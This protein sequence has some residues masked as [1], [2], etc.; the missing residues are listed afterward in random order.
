[1]ILGYDC[2]NINV[3]I[4]Y[5]ARD[6]IWSTNRTY[7]VY[8]REGEEQMERVPN[9][10]CFCHFYKKDSEDCAAKSEEWKGAEGVD[11]EKGCCML[12]FDQIR[13][14][15]DEI[16]GIENEDDQYEA[17]LKKYAVTDERFEEY[18]EHGIDSEEFLRF[19]DDIEQM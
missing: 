4:S 1:M 10:C 15:D 12:L 14:L 19:S 11:T 6:I 13:Q 7:Q 17:Y 8:Y 18:L 5:I 16:A 9:N 3:R 2:L